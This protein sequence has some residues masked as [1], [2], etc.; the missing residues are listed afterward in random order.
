MKRLALLLG[1]ALFLLM[2]TS[3]AAADCQFVLGF[4]TLRDLIGN[5]IVGECLE[6]EHH[7]AIGDSVQQTTGGLLVWRKADNWTAFTDGYRTWL[8]GPNGLVQRLNTERFEW[9]ADYAEHTPAPTSADTPTSTPPSVQ[10]P[11]P[12]SVVAANQAIAALPWVQDGLANPL[13]RLTHQELQA[14][15]AASPQVFRAWMEKFGDHALRGPF[16]ARL[17]VL[18]IVARSDEWA[19]LQ[20][21]QTPYFTDRGF[22]S[23]FSVLRFMAS[24]ESV[25]PGSLRQVLSRPEFQGGI[26]DENV[27][28]LVLL[29]FQHIDPEI[30]NGMAALSW[31]HDGV[32]ELSQR[33]SFD[34][35]AAELSE[36]ELPTLFSLMELLSRSRQAFVSL[37]SLPWIQDEIFPREYSTVSSLRTIAFWDAETAR[38]LTT[39]PFLETIELSDGFV[40]DHINSFFRNDPEGV[41]WILTQPVLAGG[42]TNDRVGEFALLYLERQDPERA[43]VLRSL[44]WIQDGLAGTEKSAAQMLGGLAQRSSDRFFQAVMRKPWVQDGLS[45]DERLVIRTIDDIARFGGPGGQEGRGD[46]AAALRIF[47]MPFLDSIERLD[48]L[49]T[50]ALDSLQAINTR[51]LQDV[52]SH[53]TLRDGIR[54]EHTALILVAGE[55][56]RVSGPE[57]ML[58]ALEPGKFLVWKRTIALPEFGNVELAVYSEHPEAAVNLDWLEHAVR[59]HVEFM[60]LPLGTDFVPLYLHRGG[61]GS[62]L[63]VGSLSSPETVA[64]EIAH[65]YWVFAPRWLQ[66]GPASFMESISENKRIGTPVKAVRDGYCSYTNTLSGLEE[67]LPRRVPS[68]EQCEYSLGSALFADLYFSLG[69]AAFRS[70]FR[71]LYLLL[72]RHEVD[73]L[74]FGREKGVCYVNRAFVTDAPAETAAIS[75]PIINR[76]YYGSEHG[77]Q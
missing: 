31:T 4:K 63:S 17:L 36:F 20:M 26:T 15:G 68:F 30:A 21:L 27:P 51:Y 70:S 39:M 77:P 61:G 57:A 18:T 13:E 72:D 56:A 24:L 50:D 6:N 66:E 37:L 49:A 42:I 46:E 53:P 58:A 22:R 76:W 8:N 12:E 52:L 65:Y 32:G 71:K 33:D 44:P 47:A 34:Y 60:G 69:D 16:P 74:C 64:H 67:Y 23:D 14:L 75:L 1:F 3:V 2:P 9:E 45:S 55:A 48:F 59:S 43:A 54:D 38:L 25:S 35:R 40:L 10:T 41:Q 7:N 19:A 11:S 62:P 5:E 73:E 29:A 28:T